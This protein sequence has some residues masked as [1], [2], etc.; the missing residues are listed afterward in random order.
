MVLDPAPEHPTAAVVTTMSHITIHRRD[1]AATTE[2][3]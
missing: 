2:V 1:T 3:S